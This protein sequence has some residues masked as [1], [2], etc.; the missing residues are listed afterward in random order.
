MKRTTLSV[1]LVTAFCALVL[2]GIAPALLANGRCSLHSVSGTCGYSLAGSILAGPAAG[3]TAGT[4][5]ITLNAD[6]TLSDG[7]QTR[8]FNG[9][10]ADETTDGSFTVNEDCTGEATVNV[11]DSGGNLVRTS[12]L[13]IVWDDGSSELRGV[14]RSAYTAINVTGRKRR[15]ND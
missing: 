9:S 4:G 2:G 8:S 7:K 3:P 6:G 14:F 11:Y 5:I 1:T 15:G 12:L 10:I 13:H